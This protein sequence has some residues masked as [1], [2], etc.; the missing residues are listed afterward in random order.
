[1]ECPPRCVK[2]FNESGIIVSGGAVNNYTSGIITSLIQLG[3]ADSQLELYKN[4]YKKRMDI[5]IRL[6]N[7]HLPKNCKFT[8]PSGGYFVW[9]TLPNHIDSN[10]LNKILMKDH[11]VAIITGDKF[12]IE[13]KFKNCFRITIGFHD[14]DTLNDGILRLCNGI[15]QFL[16]SNT[17]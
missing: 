17:I 15:N 8:I 11:K 16:N 6:L 7:D 13:Q 12:S 14:I 9:I 2:A 5:V 4:T 3:L 1:M 10:G